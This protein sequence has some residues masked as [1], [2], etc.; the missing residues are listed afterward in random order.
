MQP[1]TTPEFLAARARMGANV[2]H[3]PILTSRIL[4][5]RTGFDVRMKA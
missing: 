1:V 4:S 3:T 5:E 2:Y